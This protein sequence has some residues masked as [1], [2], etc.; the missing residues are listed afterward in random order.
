MFDGKLQISDCLAKLHEWYTWQACA[1]VLFDRLRTGL[2]LVFKQYNQW[3]VWICC[4]GQRCVLCSKFSR[5][6]SETYFGL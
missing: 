6:Y 4:K 1:C 3:F 2:R 5:S